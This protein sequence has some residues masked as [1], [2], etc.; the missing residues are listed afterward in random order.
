MEV[1][2]D[3]VGIVHL[4][5]HRNRRDEDAGHAAHNED[6][7]ESQDPPHGR[8]Q[9]DF[10]GG[11]RGNPTKNL[12]AARNRDHHAGGGKVA[13]GDLGNACREHMMDPE[14]EGEKPCRN[15]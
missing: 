11:H 9:D 7:E 5:I 1:R 6:E 15:Q 3:K 8:P 12:R 14:A 10:A 13:F 2:D 4:E